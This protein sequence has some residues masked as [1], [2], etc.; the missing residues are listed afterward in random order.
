M[1]SAEACPLPSGYLPNERPEK[2]FFLNARSSSK[3]G[4]VETPHAYVAAQ[5]IQVVCC[6]K[7]WL[8]GKVSDVELSRRVEKS[9]YSGKT[10]LLTI[11]HTIPRTEVNR[12]KTT[13]NEIIQ[14]DLLLIN[15]TCNH[16][17]ANEASALLKHSDSYYVSRLSGSTQRVANSCSPHPRKDCPTNRRVSQ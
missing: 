11:I 14:I 7:T 17:E 5:S 2:R 12:D 6:V 15:Q 9:P 13:E 4:A 16:I 8:S 10:S 3:K 1:T